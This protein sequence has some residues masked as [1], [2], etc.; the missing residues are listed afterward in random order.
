MER[1]RILMFILCTSLVIALFSGFVDLDHWTNNQNK[2]HRIAELARSMGLPEDDAIIVRAQEIW[3]AEENGVTDLTFND[4]S[5]DLEEVVEETP[6]PTRPI[7]TTQE[8]MEIQAEADHTYI[9]QTPVYTAAHTATKYTLGLENYTQDDINIIASVV[10]NEAGYGTSTRQKELTAACVVNRVNCPWVGSTV[11]E[12]VCWP[13]QYLPAY[14]QYGSYY[15]NLAME[16]DIWD[17]CC[18]IAERALRGEID[19]PYDVIFQANFPQGRKTYET[20]KTSYSISY[21]CYSLYEFDDPMLAVA[22]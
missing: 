9:D 7:K 18:E 21:F 2:A 8:E 20:H 22:N 12:V 3:W 15:M 11:Y 1:K 13:G 4:F 17:E 6:E 19:V 14:A 16:S 10:Y 5:E